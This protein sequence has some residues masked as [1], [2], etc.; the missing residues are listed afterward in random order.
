MSQAPADFVIVGSTTLARLVAGLLATVHGKRVVFAGDSHAGYR[1]ARGIDLSVGPLTRPETWSLL[2][3]VVPETARLVSRL[4]GRAAFTRVDPLFHAQTPAGKEALSHIRHAALAFGHAAERVPPGLLV[5]GSD[6]LILRDAY[7]L[8]RPA[9]EL[10]LNGWLDHSGVRRARDGEELVVRA[11]GSAELGTGDE[12]IEIVQTVLADDPAILRYVS[13]D[14]WPKLLQ[15]RV[16]ST[17]STEP[18]RPIAATVM[19]GLEDNQ[20]LVQ[21]P[22]QGITAMGIGAIDP[23]AAGLGRMLGN[24]RAFRQAGQSSYETLFT[25]DGAPAV[26]RLRGSGPDV[27]AGFGPTGAFLAP[28]MA[29]WL[30]GRA[31]PAE[32]AWLS[33]RLV[34]RNPSGSPVT[35]YG[36]A[37]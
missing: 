2:R 33:A 1:L 32:Q 27:L 19:H 18:T 29:R 22:S 36:P 31:E 7:L 30:S 12:H 11:D 23:F 15:R 13:P 16:S 17:I 20:T 21:P 34:D 8:N 24:D 37:L 25:A 6:G 4:G 35:E 26:G 10:S 28:A 3:T 14:Q 9:L 5:P